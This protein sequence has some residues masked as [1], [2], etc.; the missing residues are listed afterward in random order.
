MKILGT[1]RQ[2]LLTSSQL[3]KDTKFLSCSTILVLSN[4]RKG[5]FSAGECGADKITP[6]I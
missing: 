1:K 3:G 6:Q 2:V 4:Y 5:L